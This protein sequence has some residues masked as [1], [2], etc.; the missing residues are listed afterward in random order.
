MIM[1]GMVALSV[2]A[3]VVGISHG[4]LW[5][6]AAFFAI[7]IIGGAVLAILGFANML[8][9]AKGLMSHDDIGRPLPRRHSLTAA[10]ASDLLVRPRPSAT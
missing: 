2:V 7:D 4:F 8:G 5:G 1:I 6:V 10:I 9:G 3:I